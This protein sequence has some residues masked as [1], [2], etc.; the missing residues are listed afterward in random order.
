MDSV[1]KISPA[2]YGII[3]ICFFMPFT[4]ASCSGQKVLTLTG[5]QMV[6]GTT[7]KNSDMFG[8]RKEERIRP[9]GYAIAAFLLAAAGL[10]VS[11]SKNK[12]ASFY[13]AL[14]SCAGLVSLLMLKTKLDQDVINNGQ[15]LI[16]LEY[17][18]GYW[19]A[20]FGYMVSI[21]ANGYI[22][23]QTGKKT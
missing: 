17:N 16:R 4:T 12:K 7:I 21:V 22:Y 11:L 13:S 23:R 6:T 5:F 9:E 8:E 3:I 1:K 20:F 10:A 15:G 19:I 2:L 14:V 18:F